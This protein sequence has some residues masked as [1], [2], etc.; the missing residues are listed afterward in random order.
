MACF[1]K[2][3]KYSSEIKIF[4]ESSDIKL[5]KGKQSTRDWKFPNYKITFIICF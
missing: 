5:V 3:K 1:R 4:I 2:T